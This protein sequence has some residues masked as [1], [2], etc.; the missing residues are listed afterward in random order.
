MTAPHC[1]TAS[2]AKEAISRVEHNR[3]NTGGAG[4]GAPKFIKGGSAKNRTTETSGVSSKEKGSDWVS[5][6]GI[7]SAT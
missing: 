3:D 4:V 6:R 2:E 7:K 1:H 5:K